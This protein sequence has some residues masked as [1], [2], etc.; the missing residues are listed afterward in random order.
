M[1]N[2][3]EKVETSIK[4]AFNKSKVISDGDSVED[5]EAEGKKE[6]TK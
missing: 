3:E 1:V 2:E 4:K 6:G 5:K